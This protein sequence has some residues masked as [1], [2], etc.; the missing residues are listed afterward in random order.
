MLA[1][2]LASGR[3]YIH[4]LPAGIPQ[5]LPAAWAQACAAGRALLLSPFPPGTALN[6]QRAIWCNQYVL[7]HA[8]AVWH[9]TI[10]PGG[11]LETLLRLWRPHPA[12]MEQPLEPTGS[13]LHTLASGASSPPSRAGGASSPLLSRAGGALSPPVSTRKAT[14]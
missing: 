14:P 13:Q 2:C 9:G 6:N 3:A 11:T 5:P 7:N 8:Q 12:G 10:R 4:V 1:K